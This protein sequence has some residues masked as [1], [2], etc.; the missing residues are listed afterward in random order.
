MHPLEKF[1]EKYNLWVND[2]VL[3]LN[4]DEINEI[5]GLIKAKLPAYSVMK[6]CGHCVG[7]MFHLAFKLYENEPDF[8]G[9]V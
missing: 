9:G 3:L 5:E 8:N 7:Q 4:H 6:W 2:Q 1:R